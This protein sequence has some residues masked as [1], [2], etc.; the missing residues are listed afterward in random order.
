MAI[1]ATGCASE[2]PKQVGAGCRITTRPAGFDRALWKRCDYVFADITSLEEWETAIANG[3][4]GFTGRVLGS[5]PKGTPTKR[6]VASCLPERTTN[7]TRTFQWKDSN[8][9]LTTLTEY[10]LYQYVDENQDTLHFAI[11]T[12]DGLLIGFFE[13]WSFDV[14]DTRTEP[15]DEDAIMEASVE[16]KERLITKPIKIPGLAGLFATAVS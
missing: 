10:D 11:Y 1:C 8:A 13:E 6:R 4:V 16:V 5:K 9:D 3:D 15:N 2:I 14:D 7:Y 12:C